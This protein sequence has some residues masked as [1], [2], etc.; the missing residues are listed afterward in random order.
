MTAMTPNTRRRTGAAALVVA[1]LVLGGC[2]GKPTDKSELLFTYFTHSWP[3]SV[4]TIR[5]VVRPGRP[6]QI[7]VQVYNLVRQ[8]I[9]L[10]GV[11]LVDANGVTQH[12]TWTLTPYDL[13]IHQGSKA[14]I[15]RSSQWAFARHGWI[16]DRGARKVAGTIVPA[17]DGTAAERRGQGGYNFIY[18][19]IDVAIAGKPGD[20]AGNRPHV[21]VLGVR[22]AAHVGGKKF[23]VV[24]PVGFYGCFQ[25]PFKAP[26]CPEPVPLKILADLG[27][28]QV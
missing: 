1:A 25:E 7:R 23:T 14:V 8:N 22:V 11:E 24:L 2:G 20:E 21:T 6:E 4:T 16:H 15:V 5:H 17:W 13:T 18:L 3:D 9:V 28:P 10:D 19:N 27:L 12:D 26:L